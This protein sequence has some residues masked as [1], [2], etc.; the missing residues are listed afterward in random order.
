[1]DETTKAMIKDMLNRGMDNDTIMGVTGATQD[2]IDQV[3]TEGKSSFLDNLG[4]F[5]TAQASEIDPNNPPSM[6]PTGAMDRET[7]FGDMLKPEVPRGGSIFSGRQFDQIRGGPESGAFGVRGL[8]QVQDLPVDFSE[9]DDLEA[10][11]AE[12]AALL[13][14]AQQEERRSAL[15]TL[16]A[17]GKDIAGRSIA[18]QALGGAGGMIFGIPGAL[19]GLT[20]GALKGGDLFNRNPVI[21]DIA[22]A[23]NPFGLNMRRDAA[24]ISNMLQRGAAG[25]NFSQRNLDNVLSKFGITNIDTG[26]MMDS[27]AQ[28]AQTGYGGYGSSDAAAAAAASGGRDYSSSPGAMAGDM[29]YGEE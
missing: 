28:S 17:F 19:A 5:S 9:L 14:L 12:A 8:P 16:K 6:L 15:E 25:K 24:R 1:M 2:Q 21:A 7:P 20:F 29:E 10:Q 27:I 11:D 26:G 3:A 22:Q 4:I 13:E 23:G 18:S